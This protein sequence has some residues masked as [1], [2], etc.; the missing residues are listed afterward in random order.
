M[1]VLL[2]VALPLEAR[3]AER[4]DEVRELDVSSSPGR[5]LQRPIVIDQPG[6]Y[7]LRRDLHARDV[8]IVIRASQVTL[9]LDGHAL[10]GPAGKGVGIRIE[11]SS[12]VAVRDGSAG[13]FGTGVEVLR[14]RNVT[15]KHLR[16]LGEDRGGT[17]PDVEIGVVIVNSY[18]VLVQENVI[19]DTFLGVFVRGGDSAGNRI[20]EN[21]ITAGQNGQ[22]GVCYNPAMNEGPAGP[23]GDLVYANHIARFRTGISLSEQSVA[24]I[25][26]ANDIAYLMQALS[27]ASPGTNVLAENV[28][29]QTYL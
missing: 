12:G 25:I 24:N 27:E 22:I 10:W 23:R 17:P 6:K 8:A 1:A 14:S 21:V 5:R 16:I 9:D 20:A 26:R 15:L 13:W 7:V 4:E 29:V 28:S 3:T 19:V 18:G 2:L 11:D